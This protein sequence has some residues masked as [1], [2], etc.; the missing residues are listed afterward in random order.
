MRLPT[1]SSGKNACKDA[2]R[3]W[4]GGISVRGAGLRPLGADWFDHPQRAVTERAHVNPFAG[5]VSQARVACPLRQLIGADHLEVLVDKDVVW[6]VDADVVDLV[7]AVAQ[8]HNTVD[9][10]PR[11]GRQRSFGCLIGCRSADDRS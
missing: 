4:C 1:P 8:L 11:V 6:P 2:G 3:P 9:D 7:F 10:A 5:T